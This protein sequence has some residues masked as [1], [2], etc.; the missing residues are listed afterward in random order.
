MATTNGLPVT[1]ERR[2]LT[3]AEAIEVQR[4]RNYSASGWLRALNRVSRNDPER[5]ARSA[6]IL[7]ELN[8][9]FRPIPR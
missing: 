3:P 9:T 5:L 8:S 6:E 2:L 7:S 1:T 4:T